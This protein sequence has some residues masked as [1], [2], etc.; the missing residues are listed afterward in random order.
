MNRGVRVRYASPP[1]SRVRPHLHVRKGDL[2]LVVAGNDKGK[3]GT[4]QAVVRETNR[5]IVEGVNLRWKHRKPTQSNPKGERVQVER[6][7]HAS[8]VMHVDPKTGKPSRRRIGES[9]GRGKAAPA[10]KQ[11]KEKKKEAAAS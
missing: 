2:V 8:N 6:S 4:I 5:V 1:E 10:K 11:K 3:Q 9:K 7:I